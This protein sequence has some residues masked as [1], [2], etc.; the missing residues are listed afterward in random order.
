VEAGPTDRVCQTCFA[1][2]SFR[3]RYR[4]MVCQR[5]LDRPKCPDCP[6][7]P[8]ES[9]EERVKATPQFS[10]ERIS[11][12][13]EP[14]APPPKPKKARSAPVAPPPSP[15]VPAA[16]PS[17]LLLIPIASAAGVVVGCLLWLLTWATG[18]DSVPFRGLVGFLAGLVAGSILAVVRAREMRRRVMIAVGLAVL[19]A[20][21][22]LAGGFIT[23]VPAGLLGGLVVGIFASFYPPK[24]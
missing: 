22:G 20:C 1:E 24:A 21:C 14:E 8:D 13:A 7:K 16:K 11:A 23:W 17:P 15:P 5:L 10:I 4:C 12:M 18:I 9:D 19:G 6:D 2:D 3:K